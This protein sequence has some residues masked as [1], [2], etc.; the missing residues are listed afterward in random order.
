MKEQL[1]HAIPPISLCISVE[2]L[3]SIIRS[4]LTAEL[5]T[6]VTASPQQA[7]KEVRAEKIRSYI[8]L[9]PDERSLLYSGGLLHQRVIPQ[10]FDR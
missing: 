4:D 8:E 7:D 6:H 1:S 10:R 2:L 3:M 9:H 5:T